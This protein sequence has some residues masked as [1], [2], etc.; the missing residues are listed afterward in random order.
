L[1]ARWKLSRLLQ[2]SKDEQITAYRPSPELVEA[3]R[4]R[5]EGMVSYYREAVRSPSFDWKHEWDYLERL[6]RSCYLQ[7]AHDTAMV[8]AQLADKKEAGNG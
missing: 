1:I 7:G 6:A 8:A 2:I 4:E 5:T 3:A